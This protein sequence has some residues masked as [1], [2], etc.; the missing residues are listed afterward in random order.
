MSTQSESI[1]E[2]IENGADMEFEC[3]ICGKTYESIGKCQF[4]ETICELRHSTD[5]EKTCWYCNNPS[6]TEYPTYI[7][8]RHGKYPDTDEECTEIEYVADEHRDRCHSPSYNM[9]EMYIDYL[10]MQ[11][12]EEEA[13]QAA[14]PR[15]VEGVHESA[16]FRAV[17][18]T[19]ASIRLEH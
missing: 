18:S 16:R 9:D 2:I 19:H 4:H 14:I 7:C 13:E 5:P 17:C 8:R 11:A 10:A 3:N 6:K 15:R 12:E 1:A